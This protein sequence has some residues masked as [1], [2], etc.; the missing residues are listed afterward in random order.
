MGNN[1]QQNISAK[2]IEITNDINILS[3]ITDAM[4]GYFLSGLLFIIINLVE[5]FSMLFFSHAS[6][7]SINLYRAFSFLQLGL[8]IVVPVLGV[9]IGIIKGAKNNNKKINKIIK[10]FLLLVPVLW[11]TLFYFVLLGIL[12][13]ALSIISGILTVKYLNKKKDNI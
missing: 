9:I 13:P 10:F 1:I 5:I 2:R 7:T 12:V 11:L 8:I 3:V 6:N 4:L